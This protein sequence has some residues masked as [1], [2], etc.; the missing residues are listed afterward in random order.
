MMARSVVFLNRYYWPEQS[1]TG[2][3][4]TD[5]AEDLAGQGWEVTVLTG[6]GPS[7][8]SPR[9]PR[10]E[11][12]NGVRILRL[13]GRLLG[14]PYR[15]R[16]A[17]SYL[18][19]LASATLALLRIRRPDVVVAMT[20]PPLLILPALLASRLRRART[21]YWVQGIFPHQAARLGL[22]RPGSLAERTLH[23]L[24]RHVHRACDA[25][26]APGEGMSEV[27]LA[28]GAPRDRL[29]C[30]HNWADTTGIRPVAPEAN[31]FRS[32]NGL[33]DKFVVL[34]SGSAGRAHTFGAVLDAAWLLRDR[35]D[36]LFLFIGGGQ[37]LPHLESEVW[38]YGLENVRFMD[39]LPADRLADSLS[40][41]NVSLVTENPEFT[42]LRI[43]S[44]T[45][46]ILA[47]GR[48][49]LFVGSDDSE[50]TRIIT[51]L[52]CGIV[53]PHDNG[54][55][56][57][58]AVLRLQDSPEEAVAMGKQA[59]LAAVSLFNRRTS[60]D[61]W[62]DLLERLLAPPAPVRP[63][64]VARRKPTVSGAEESQSRRRAFSAGST[65]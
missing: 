59:R 51:S 23:H 34:Y 27:L 58:A 63:L 8:G 62:R 57:A 5:L 60:G 10:G 46:R 11:T 28:A 2:Q 37:E 4:L 49:L 33:Q 3:M 13:H 61:L 29:A 64:P 32:E 56:L 25:M 20:D 1:A 40:A 36:V 26:V 42:G 43:P 41:A 30:I 53:V 19:Y 24:A 54:E 65:Q 47:S 16:R 48:P 38:R 21:V 22:L 50:V 7:D 18:A 52:D 39:Y 15:V 31:E 6:G 9:L 55:A 14:R 35:Q 17:L 45:Y 12:V 44:K